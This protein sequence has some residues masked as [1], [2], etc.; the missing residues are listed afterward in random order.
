[1]SF[2][3]NKTT[4]EQVFMNDNLFSFNEIIYFLKNIKYWKPEHYIV[5]AKNDYCYSCIHQSIYNVCKPF[6]LPKSA[7]SFIF[8]LDLMIDIE[9]YIV[10]Q[11]KYPTFNFK[12]LGKN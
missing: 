4:N 1:M 3:F 5:I 7:T 2:I 9:N 10:L 12:I 6:K 11:K 8:T